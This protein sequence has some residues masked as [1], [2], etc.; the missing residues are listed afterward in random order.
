MATNTPAALAVRRALVERSRR[1]RSLR[2]PP[3]ATPPTGVALSYSRNLVELDRES[4]ALILSIAENALPRLVELSGRRDA[5]VVILPRTGVSIP[6]FDGPADELIAS[7]SDDL[8]ERIAQTTDPRRISRII[9][10]AAE[11]TN[12]HNTFQL[13]R[14]AQAVLGIPFPSADSRLGQQLDLFRSEN[15][16][17]IRDL[18]EEKAKKVRQLLARAARGGAR[19]EDIARELRDSLG[20]SP[21]RA[22]LI[23]RDQVLKLNGQLTEARHLE[24]GVEEFTWI[25]SMDE[26]TRPDHAALHG[27]VFRWDRLPIVASRTGRRGRPGEDFKCRCTADPVFRLPN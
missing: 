8:L 7:I 3:P 12:A 14:Q 27:K 10:A 15:V 25:A 17:L 6:R 24:A 20:F 26:R 5:S 1:R 13:D 19:A 16:A 21:A 18:A 2:K 9:E 23:A 4:T 11:S 22:R